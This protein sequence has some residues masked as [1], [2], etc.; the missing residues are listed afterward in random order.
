[1]IP[2]S[3]IK[4]LINFINFTYY[5]NTARGYGYDFNVI[6][7]INESKNDYK[8]ISLKVIKDIFQSMIILRKKV[9][10]IL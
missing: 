1:M 6:D 7:K 3:K 10:F 8:L 5:L 2:L 9:I 4:P